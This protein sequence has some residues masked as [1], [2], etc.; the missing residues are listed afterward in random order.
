MIVI[1]AALRR[2]WSEKGSSTSIRSGTGAAQGGGGGAAAGTADDED[3]E[4]KSPTV[5]AI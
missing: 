3:D 2:R 5:R 1:Q 4:G